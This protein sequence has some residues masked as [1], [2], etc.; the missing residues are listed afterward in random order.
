MSNEIRYTIKHVGINHRDE[1]E[2]RSTA[3]TLCALFG[4]EIS[5]ETPAALFAGEIFEVMKHDRRGAHGH[6]ALQT[7]DV[8]AAMA[9]LRAKGIGFQED[10]IRRDEAGRIRFVYLEQQVA[11]FAFHLTT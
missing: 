4:L 1:D 6:V 2:A 11:G 9:D 5:Q 8:E 10:T 3:E 7:D